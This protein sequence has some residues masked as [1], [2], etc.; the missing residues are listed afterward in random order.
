MGSEEAAI[1]KAVFSVLVLPNVVG[2][3][4]VVFVILRSPAMK[5][6]MNY[7]LLNLAASDLLVGVGMFPNIILSDVV[8][9]PRGSAGNFLCKVVLS[10]NF[11]WVGATA[12][13]CSLVF[14]SIERY[15]VIMKPL[16]IR[17]RITNKKLRL[18]V[19]ISWVTA[20]VFCSPLFFVKRLDEDGLCTT[21]WP[22][23]W[24]KHA[25]YCLWLLVGAVLPCATMAALYAR[26]IRFLWSRD[27]GDSGDVT[28]QAVRRSRKKVTV[29]MLAL[30]VVYAVCWF[31][32]LV[33]HVVSNAA[34]EQFSL[35][36]PVHTVAICLVVV[37]SSVNPV[38]YAF[39]FEQFKRE[40]IKIV[41]CCGVSNDNRVEATIR[42]ASR[43][44][45][46][47]TGPPHTGMDT[48]TGAVHVG[49]GSH[50]HELGHVTPAG[51]GDTVTPTRM[52]SEAHACATRERGPVIPTTGERVITK[53]VTTR[54]ERD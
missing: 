30:S 40:L 53:D 6:P 17:Y 3:S 2:N 23:A 39:R 52:T 21:T 27:G 9:Y 36:H 54:D 28:S 24:Y 19:L 37:N 44:P 29:T 7:L 20:V 31:P 4:L 11:A 34:P 43:Q 51:D 12:S 41:C 48:G 13:A 25:Y 45:A 33:M 15:H 1:F 32:D 35:D 22:D 26:V 38:V 46:R 10:A 42:G 8:D 47:Q 5:S 50:A 49:T 14:I 18:F 16:D